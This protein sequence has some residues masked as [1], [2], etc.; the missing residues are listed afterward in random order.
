MTM[1]VAAHVGDCVL[2]AADKRA[3]ICDLETGSM[4]LENDLEQ[5]IK[6]WDR[7]AVA[8]TGESVFLD[9]VAR[10][11]VNYKEEDG[12]LRQMDAIQNELARRIGEGVP[13]A[14]LLHNDIIFSI[15]NGEETKLYTI[16]TDQFFNEFQKDGQNIIRVGV[17][18]ITKNAAVITC[19]NIPTDFTS[20]V[21]FQKYIKSLKDFDS[22]QAFISYYITHLK[23]VFATHSA[24]D[25][26]ITPSFDL[27]IQSCAT[28]KSIA[29]HVQN[30][31]LS[32]PIPENLNYWID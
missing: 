23:E 22:D 26:S 19:F 31:A 7:G 21:N 1:I 14:A 9:R 10:Y 24:I 27:Y 30:F 6:L 5:K 32:A 29:V 2:I 8:G 17:D 3:M 20:F 13:P 12:L 4:S 18:E 25:P 28:G 15:F 11:F 16:Q